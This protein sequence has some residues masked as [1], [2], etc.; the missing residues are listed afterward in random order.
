MEAFKYGSA[1]NVYPLELPE[2]TLS[3]RDPIDADAS[4]TGLT[5]NLDPQPEC[6][7]LREFIDPL[8]GGLAA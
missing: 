7:L 8:D 4:A 5:V 2:D 6:I 3:L 1:L